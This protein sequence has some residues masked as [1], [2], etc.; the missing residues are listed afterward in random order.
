MKI[1]AR[2]ALVNQSLPLECGQVLDRYEL[3]Y[4]T[5]GELNAQ[6]DNA[7]LIC[8]GYT[9]NQ[10]AAGCG[11]SGEAKPGWWDAAIGPGKP[12]DTNRFFVL[13]SNVLGG[14]GGSSC[15]ASLKWWGSNAASPISII[16]RT[17]TNWRFRIPWTI[18]QAR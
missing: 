10:H 3:A 13:S 11:S 4:E 6:K 1:I 17:A 9:A 14:A 15:A 7:I 8:H 5:Y 18:L 2:T 12:I 16:S